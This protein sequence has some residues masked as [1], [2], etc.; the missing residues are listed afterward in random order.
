MYVHK[1][2][3]EKIFYLNLIYSVMYI[4][5]WIFINMGSQF[6]TIVVFQSIYN[7]GTRILSKFMN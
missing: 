5:M 7:N 4:K 6:I 3:K 2:Y 1:I